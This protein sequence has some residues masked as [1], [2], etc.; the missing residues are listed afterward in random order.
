MDQ[1]V[2]PE[3]IDARG[4]VLENDHV[5]TIFQHLVYWLFAV[6]PGIPNF[7]EPL[8]GFHDPIG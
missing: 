2:F 4:L 6:S 1:Q 7:L 8:H 3:I 5:Q